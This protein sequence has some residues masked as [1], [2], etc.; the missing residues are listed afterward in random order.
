MPQAITVPDRG[1]EP[2]EAHGLSETAQKIADFL[3]SEI[4]EGKFLPGQKLPSLSHLK[5]MF[6]MPPSRSVRSALRQLSREGL[7][8][9]VE[10]V[11]FVKQG[12]DLT[13]QSSGLVSE[14]D[15]QNGGVPG[16]IITPAEE[17]GSPRL[18]QR[19]PVPEAGHELTR[20]AQTPP[21]EWPTADW[22]TLREKGGVRKMHAIIDYLQVK[23]KPFLDATG[24]VVTL[25][26]LEQ[27]DPGAG[28]ALR[29][30]LERHPMPS[31]LRFVR[32]DELMNILAER[33]TRLVDIASC[34]RCSPGM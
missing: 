2:P 29:R 1:A 23:W 34:S 16:A 28:V 25:E 33:P 7:I 18:S 20:P 14:R 13:R 17:F 15:V 32:H 10:D 22:K 26:I 8:S 31:E 19:L 4:A 6:G 12:P 5:A 11:F 21:V 27:K 24:A 30:Y 3:R 9:V